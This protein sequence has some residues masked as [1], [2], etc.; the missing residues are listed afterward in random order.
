M[1]ELRRLSGALERINGAIGDMGGM[2]ELHRHAR[3]PGRIPARR[4]R[5]EALAADAARLAGDDADAAV[6]RGFAA[7]VSRTLSPE[8]FF[9][10]WEVDLDALGFESEPVVRNVR[11]VMALAGGSV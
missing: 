7:A 2:Q 9:R 5:A 1:T 11:R 8:E 6:L 4:R 10:A 3:R